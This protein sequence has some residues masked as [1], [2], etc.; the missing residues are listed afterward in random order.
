MEEALLPPIGLALQEGVFQHSVQVCGTQYFFVE[1]IPMGRIVHN[2]DRTASLAGYREGYTLRPWG[3]TL[4]KSWSAL[5]Q[6]EE[7]IGR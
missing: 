3:K 4:A 5:P 2:G 1:I 7:H 6:T